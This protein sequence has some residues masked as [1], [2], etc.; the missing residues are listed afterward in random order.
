MTHSGTIKVTGDNSRGISA[1]A[2]SGDVK[3]LGSVTVQ[4]ANAI[5]LALQGDIGGALVRANTVR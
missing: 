4:G 2:V 1:G 5:G 3:I